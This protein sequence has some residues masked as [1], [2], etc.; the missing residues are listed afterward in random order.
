MKL[1]TLYRS[2]SLSAHSLV[3]LVDVPA[4]LLAGPRR[5]VDE[6]QVIL[7]LVGSVSNRGFSAARCCVC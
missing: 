4:M 1:E 3:I 2:L 6:R 5:F 7:D